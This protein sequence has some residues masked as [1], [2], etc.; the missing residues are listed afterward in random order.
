[1]SETRLNDQECVHILFIVQKLFLDYNS[2][3]NALDLNKFTFTQ[4]HRIIS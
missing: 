2:A 4:L 1:M 3:V